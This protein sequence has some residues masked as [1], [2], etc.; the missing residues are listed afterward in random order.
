MSFFNEEIIYDF[1][2]ITAKGYCQP[3][4]DKEEVSSDLEVEEATGNEPAITLESYQPLNCLD[5]PSKGGYTKEQLYYFGKNVLKIPYVLM[6]KGENKLGKKYLCKIINDRFRTLKQNELKTEN[7]YERD[8]DKC[9]LGEKKGGYKLQELRELGVQHFGL[10]VEKANDMSK[11]QLCAHIIPIVK[12][13]KKGSNIIEDIKTADD[14]SAV[15][16]KNIDL[17]V[18][19]KK[20]GGYS[21]KELIN[22]AIHK[23][24]LKITND[25]LK[26]E[27]CKLVKDKITDIKNI[28]QQHIINQKQGSK[29]RHHDL[30]AKRIN[31]AK[32]EHAKTLK[33]LDILD[34]SNSK[35][36]SNKSKYT[37]KHYTL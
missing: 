31:T 34:I 8:I 9:L 11:E 23:L 19:S 22:I 3:P 30:S 18:K 7:F 17:C 36:V 16:K 5:T 26:D 15:Y 32:L 35:L 33:E 37:K 27:I 1:M 4:G 10:S 2:N 14:I 29:T 12:K 20:R 24:G 21:R 28:K 6:K 25:M 13:T